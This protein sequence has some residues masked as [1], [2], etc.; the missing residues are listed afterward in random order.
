MKH[1]HIRAQ[2][3]YATTDLQGLDQGAE[4]STA[5][6]FPPPHPCGAAVTLPYCGATIAM[7]PNQPQ[8][9][10]E[11]VL[12]ERE[13]QIAS[14][15]TS[16]SDDEKT[17]WQMLNLVEAHARDAGDAWPVSRQRRR[18]KDLTASLVK[19]IATGLATLER[20]AREFPKT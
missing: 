6:P 20:L 12:A 4:T 1:H 19:T 10:L 5:A 13:R 14:G 18:P 2:A 11:S 17:V 8:T 15:H 7:A 16:A 9:A 3:P